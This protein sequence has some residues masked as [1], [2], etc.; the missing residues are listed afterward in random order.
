MRISCPS[1]VFSDNPFDIRFVGKNDEDSYQKTEIVEG[2]WSRPLWKIAKQCKNDGKS[3]CRW[4]W[5]Y[6]N[7]AWYEKGEQKNDEADKKG[8]GI[9]NHKDTSARSDT[10]SASKAGKDCPDMACYGCTPCKQSDYLG[11]NWYS[12]RGERRDPEDGYNPLAYIDNTDKYPRFSSRNAEGVRSSGV[13]TPV[14][15]DV[16][17][18]Q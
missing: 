4:Y 2:I 10:L 5:R 14:F 8:V 1:F 7:D 9:E 16:D 12:L 13:T 3:H 11:I 18:L 6:G 15:P 17:S